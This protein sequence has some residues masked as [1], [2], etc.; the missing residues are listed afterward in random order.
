[1]RSLALVGAVAVC[2]LS[3]CG[4]S[5]QLTEMAW[6]LHHEDRIHGVEGMFDQVFDTSGEGHGRRQSMDS[7]TGNSTATASSCVQAGALM[8]DGTCTC[9]ALNRSWI[10]RTFFIEQGYWI[11]G[12]WVQN[13]AGIPFGGSAVVNGQTISMNSSCLCAQPYIHSPY[14]SDKV[15]TFWQGVQNRRLRSPEESAVAVMKLVGAEWQCVCPAGTH[16]NPATLLCECRTSSGEFA[17][18]LDGGWCKCPYMSSYRPT[19]TSDGGYSSPVDNPKACLCTNSASS[20][21]V[22]PNVSSGHT[23]KY[24]PYYGCQCL[25]DSGLVWYHTAGECS[26]NSPMTITYSGGSPRCSCPEYM[27]RY[28]YAYAGLDGNNRSSAQCACK[29]PAMYYQGWNSWEAKGC[30]CRSPF[31]EVGNFPVASTAAYSNASCSCPSD[32]TRHTNPYGGS[33]DPP[34]AYD[35]CRCDGHYAGVYYSTYEGKCVCSSPYVVTSNSSGHKSCSCSAEKGM[36]EVTVHYSYWSYNTPVPGGSLYNYSYT[37]CQCMDPRAYIDSGECRCPAPYA[38]TEVG[39]AVSCACKPPMRERS[40]NYTYWNF[41]S[42]P[43]GT[44]I[45][46]PYN[47][48]W[49]TCECPSELGMTYS[50][51]GECTCLSDFDMTWKHDSTTN[52]TRM[53]CS[54]LAPRVLST[55]TYVTGGTT[56]SSYANC[57]CPEPH[58]SYYNSASKTCDCNYPMV[59]NAQG[60]CVCPSGTHEKV[61]T[62]QSPYIVPPSR[63]IT[64]GCPGDDD[65]MAQISI[66]YANSNSGYN[67]G[68]LSLSGSMATT[69][70]SLSNSGSM[71]HNNSATCY[72]NWDTPQ[73]GG[74][75]GC[76]SHLV[77]RVN[78]MDYYKDSQ[79]NSLKFG[80]CECAVYG[81]VSVYKYN[82]G[83]VR[84]AVYIVLCRGVSVFADAFFVVR[85]N[86]LR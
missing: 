78:V 26:C 72:C 75:C 47:Y 44:S 9:P 74:G 18:Y 84:E 42:G 67:S 63:Y 25:K 64:C 57:E 13:T 66:N 33:Y 16:F 81:A 23:A 85:D 28:T 65:Q 36:H 15:K 49:T 82:N 83:Q 60:M 38:L 73:T 24:D 79:N 46:E 29:D 62:Y 50:G 69:G 10:N 68:S 4:V 12:I 11:N 19:L 45:L 70:W 30:Y 71:G 39:G 21:W 22:Y 7:I 61:W 20:I 76:P 3:S 40:Y 86:S 37:Q 1:M 80:R 5:G 52:K 77:K 58:K 2:L 27:T 56:A 35:N 17:G 31:H 14:F 6:D 55:Y 41:V 51:W 32:L 48:T 8:V 59:K 43:N 53:E 54:C 34:Q